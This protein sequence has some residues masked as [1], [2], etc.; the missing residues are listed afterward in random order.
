MYPATSLTAAEERDMLASSPA[1]P[2]Y[3]PLHCSWLPGGRGDTFQEVNFL[4]A[5]SLGAARC[6]VDASHISQPKGE[7]GEKGRDYDGT[8][9][10]EEVGQVQGPAE[11]VRRMTDRLQ[12]HTD[13]I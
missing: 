10:G 6:G 3:T 2:A 13:N 1:T 12:H 11:V 8:R 7:T 5:G 9:C 4:L